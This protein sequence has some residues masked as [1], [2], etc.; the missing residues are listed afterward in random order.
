M[1]KRRVFFG[2]VNISAVNVECVGI[3][4]VRLNEDAPAVEID[5]RVVDFDRRRLPAG[6]RLR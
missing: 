3:P 1:I 6:R 2:V 4:F 5:E